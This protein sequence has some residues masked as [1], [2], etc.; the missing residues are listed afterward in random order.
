VSVSPY[1]S[2]Q[3]AFDGE[4]IWLAPGAGALLKVEP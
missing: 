2:A 4:G 1:N 3:A